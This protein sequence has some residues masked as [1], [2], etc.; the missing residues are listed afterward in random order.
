MTLCRVLQFFD[1]IF[2]KQF[3]DVR[4][5]ICKFFITDS[6]QFFAFWLRIRQTVNF[7]R[8]HFKTGSKLLRVLLIIEAVFEVPEQ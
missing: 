6:A 7:D 3:V 5:E 2:R 1:D 4:F 8:T